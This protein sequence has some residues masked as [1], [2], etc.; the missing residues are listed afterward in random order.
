M[1]LKE[2]FLEILI[3]SLSVMICNV[4]EKFS[5]L[6]KNLIFETSSQNIIFFFIKDVYL[7]FGFTLKL[8]KKVVFLT[9][10]LQFF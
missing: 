1:T 2:Y 6:L 8:I 3:F 4:I 9:W 5:F 10:L 7:G